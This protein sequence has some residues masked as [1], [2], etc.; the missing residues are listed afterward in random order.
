MARDVMSSWEE[1]YETVRQVRLNGLLM[2]VSFQSPNEQEKD[3]W[4]ARE[5]RSQMLERGVWAIG[6]KEDSIRMYPALNMDDEVLMEGLSLLE[7][8]IVHVEQHG[9]TVGNAPRVPTGV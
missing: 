7:E 1:K 9:Q 4:Y 6:D 2:G 3:L 5:I 8:A